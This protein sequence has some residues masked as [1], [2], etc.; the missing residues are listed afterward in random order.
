MS[1]SGSAKLF[2]NASS[3]LARSSRTGEEPFELLPTLI[4]FGRCPLLRLAA[5]LFIL[6]I[7]TVSSCSESLASGSFKL[8]AI[9]ISNNSV[10][11]TFSNSSKP[12]ESSRPRFLLR[13]AARFEVL[14][15]TGAAA[16]GALL[17]RDPASS[18]DRKD[19]RA[20]RMG[21]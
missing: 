18:R 3:K 17:M 9:A 14:A 15:V 5:A 12:S 6:I 20:L 10:Q 7:F 19:S 4:A 11:A 21:G 13:R 2:A 8:F 1:A 16:A